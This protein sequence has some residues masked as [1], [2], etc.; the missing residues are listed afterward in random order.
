MFQ[1]I[2]RIA[3][4]YVVGYEA[5][6]RFPGGPVERSPQEWFVLA[7]SCGLRVDLEVACWKAIAAQGPPPG[8]AMLFVNTSPVALVD[9]RLNAVRSELPERLVVELTEQDAV[10]D[11]ELLRSKLQSWSNDGVR[12]AIDDTG[13]GYSSLQH[14]LQLAP[15]FL[16]LDRS[17][18]AGVDRERSR[19][20]LVRSLVAFA[21]EVGAVVVAECVERPEEL[22]VLAEA[23]VALAQG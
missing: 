5:L 19:R 8:D 1:P 11:Y 12:L 4:G 22:E 18:I 13:A 9:H 14:V 10:H 17:M 23:G 20:V 6:A 2:V 3:D 16:K 7:Q 21:R 15:D